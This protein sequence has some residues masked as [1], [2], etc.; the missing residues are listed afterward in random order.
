MIQHL[1]P[2]AICKGAPAIIKVPPHTLYVRVVA[3]S[4]VVADIRPVN[5]QIC[6]TEDHVRTILNAG[7]NYFI[8]VGGNPGV[9]LAVGSCAAI[10]EVVVSGI[11]GL[12]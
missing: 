8:A 2:V 5:S 12:R 11:I 1:R 7:H 10:K 6:L 4:K 3:G 9:I